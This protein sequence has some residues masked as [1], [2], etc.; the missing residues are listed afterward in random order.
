MP[1]GRGALASTSRA[2]SHV[3][4]PRSARGGGG[5]SRDGGGGGGNS[6]DDGD[7][8]DPHEKARLRFEE[9][10]EREVRASVRAAA[11]YHGLVPQTQFMVKARALRVWG[12][13]AGAFRTA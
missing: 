12:A 4:K 5:S 10:L 3:A 9:R 1:L 13:S 6:T 11:S 7:A 8:D 2:G